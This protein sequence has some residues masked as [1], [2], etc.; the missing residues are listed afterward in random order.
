MQFVT[1]F[2]LSAF[3][4]CATAAGNDNAWHITD[5]SASCRDN[6]CSY[7]FNVAGDATPD[8]P[9]FQAQ[10]VGRTG[11]DDRTARPCQLTGPRIVT[12]VQEV[13]SY[14]ALQPNGG[15]DDAGGQLFLELKFANG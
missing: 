1:T 8:L 9:A 6:E 13:N 7:L 12:S 10:C 14:V 3:A 11:P 5:F 15:G 4:A 2:L